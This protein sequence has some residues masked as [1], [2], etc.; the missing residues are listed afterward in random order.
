MNELDSI[1]EILSDFKDKGIKIY[2]DDFGTGY[3]SLAYLKNLPID[4][5]KIDKSFIDEMLTDENDKEIVNTTI[6]LGHALGKIIVAEG[7]EN[8]ET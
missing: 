3:S 5:I 1:K 2:I 6:K 4:C 8:K 7:V